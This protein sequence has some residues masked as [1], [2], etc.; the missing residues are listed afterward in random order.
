MKAPLVTMSRL[1]IITD[2]GTAILYLFK[3]FLCIDKTVSNFWQGE[4]I[5]LMYNIMKYAKNPETLR[6]SIES[7]L[8]RI[9]NRFFDTVKIQVELTSATGLSLADTPAVNISMAIL[10]TDE[11]KDYSLSAVLNDAFADNDRIFERVV[12]RGN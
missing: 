9:Y 7:D 8:S 1:G 4:V 2:A 12:F 5:S 11:G 6:E 10:V 3:S